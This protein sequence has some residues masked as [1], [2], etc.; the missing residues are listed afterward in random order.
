MGKNDSLIYAG[1]AV[2]GLGGFLWYFF[3]EA[4]YP[5][6]RQ[7]FKIFDPELVRMV[8]ARKAQEAAAMYGAWQ[9]TYY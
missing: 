8:D 1:V 7:V 5:L 4:G 2:L 3:S 6:R 9:R